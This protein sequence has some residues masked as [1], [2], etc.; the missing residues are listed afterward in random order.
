MS[1]RRTLTITT[2]LVLAIGAAF[3]V[4]AFA[5]ST[6]VPQR[7]LDQ[8]A[9]CQDARAAA[10]TPHAQAWAE[11]CVAGIQAAID[12]WVTA[13]PEP[14]TAPPTVPPTTVPPTTPPAT[15]PPATTT[16][17][18]TTPPATTPPSS[19]KFPDATNTGVPAFTALT[20]YTG[21]CTITAAGTVIDAKTVNC[22]LTI[23][24]TGVKITR[25]KVNGSVSDGSGNNAAASFSVTDTEI[26]CGVDTTCV[27]ESHFT[28]LRVNVH[29][30]NRDAHCYSTCTATDSWF[31]GIRFTGTG[32]A[33]AFRLGQYTTLTHD[34]ISCD[35]P[36]TSVGGGCSAD[37]TGYPDFEPIH[38]N[39]MTG[40]YLTEPEGAYYHAYGGAS[41][42]KPYSND[43]TNATYIVFT[44]NV[45][46]H[47]TWFNGSPVT[48]FAAGRTGNV[49][50]GNVWLDGKP[51]TL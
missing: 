22:D 43:P 21:P 31:H 41:A 3:V 26:V 15:V 12:A 20:A 47:S 49:F 5:A 30:G 23:Q 32:H 48:D 4:P 28:L 51:V 29:G 40:C 34:T 42:T 14:T 2:A 8:L 45:F 36:N 6:A 44:G 37:V 11:D 27:G 39:T 18:A 50:S 46:Q 24:T 7:L 10:T 13:H 38:H 17:P 9:N 1:R 19:S 25:S 33:S 16:P 35:A